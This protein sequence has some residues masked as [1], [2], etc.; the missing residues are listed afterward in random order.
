VRRPARALVEAAD[1]GEQVVR[2]CV[3]VRGDLGG[4]VGEAVD[5]GGRE[6]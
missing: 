3:E 4:F 6:R 5:F 2:C 1:E